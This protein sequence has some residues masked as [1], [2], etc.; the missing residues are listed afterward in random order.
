MR[1]YI[2]GIAALVLETASITMLLRQGPF[3][4][5]LNL[6]ALVVAVAL[7]WWAALR[8]GLPGAAAG[9][10]TVITSTASRPSGESGRLA[11]LPLRSLRGLALARNEAPVRD[12]RRGARMERRRPLFRWERADRAPR[13]RRR[14][15]RRSL[16]GDG[17]VLRNGSGGRTVARLIFVTGSLS[18]GGAERHTLGLM[19]RL[20]ERGHQCHAVCVKRIVGPG[21]RV[22]ACKAASRREASPRHAISTC[23]RWQ[24]SRCSLVAHRTVGDRR[25][26]SVRP[27]ALLARS[28]PRAPAHA[29]GGHL[30]L[31][32]RL[33][34][35][36][37]RLP[38]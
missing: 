34:R 27:H 35:S 29:P 24:I 22:R 12:S 19:N 9:S 20:S 17:R 31:R 21:I 13:R 14:G 25:R 28:A 32:H 4:M 3:V 8:F 18:P 2:V 26:E 15:S 16:R 36:R 38:R 5:C 37:E 10:V 33:A 11:R 1:V 7:D 23:A 6:V 30:S